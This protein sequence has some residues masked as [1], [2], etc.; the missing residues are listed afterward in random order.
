M[1]MMMTMLKIG[2]KIMI[3]S[4]KLSTATETI[5]E[6]S[7]MIVAASEV[8]P[9]ASLRAILALL[10]L[11]PL[12]LT[13]ASLLLLI[14]GFAA[15]SKADNSEL[16]LSPAAPPTFVIVLIPLKRLVFDFDSS[17]GFLAKDN[18]R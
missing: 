16:M 3:P 5:F 4:T 14:I 8:S 10:L 17:S 11:A 15:E 1:I 13:G 2:V 6:T 7:P 18:D 12:L 9:A